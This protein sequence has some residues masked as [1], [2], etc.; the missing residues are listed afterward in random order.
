METGYRR[1]RGRDGLGRGD[2]KPAAVAGA[3]CGP[4]GLPAVILGAAVA[5]LLFVLWRGRDRADE[6]LPF[7][8]FLALAMVVVRLR[9]SV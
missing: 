1:L 6:L 4:A 3:W 9:L 5:G 7:A 8:P 2:A